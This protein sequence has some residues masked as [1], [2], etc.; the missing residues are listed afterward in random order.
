[1]FN[2][3]I[4]DGSVATGVFSD[5]DWGSD[6][7]FLQIS[8]DVNGGTD[9]VLMGTTQ[10]LAVPYALYAKNGSKW[11]NNTTGID[12]TLGNVGIGTTSPATKLEVANGDVYV[13][14]P[15]KGIILKSP[16]GTCFR[17]T[18]DDSGNFVK[19]QITCPQ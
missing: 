19:T 5:I 1:M 4:G 6:D 12:Y 18:I 9:Y 10:L 13:S 16:N 11:N 7:K 17:V 15:T 2:L 3:A 8:L 14:D